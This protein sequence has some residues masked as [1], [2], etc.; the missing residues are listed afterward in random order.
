MNSP[1]SVIGHYS[2][3]STPRSVRQRHMPSLSFSPIVAE[4][5]QLRTVY[6]VDAVSELDPE[7]PNQVE[8][9]DIRETPANHE[10]SVSTSPVVPVPVCPQFQVTS[11]EM[12]VPVNSEVHLERVQPSA[13]NPD[14]LSAQQCNLAAKDTSSETEETG[15]RRSKSHEKRKSIQKRGMAYLSHL[16]RS[17]PSTVLQNEHRG[18]RKTTQDL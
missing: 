1:G 15:S 12:P 5:P 7:S 18:S 4:G 10:N 11:P 3:I 8:P 16:K 14:T 13:R 9:D 2:S 17:S 6:L